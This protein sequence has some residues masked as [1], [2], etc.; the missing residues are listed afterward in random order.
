MQTNLFQSSQHALNLNDISAKIRAVHTLYACWQAG[1]CVLEHDAE[2]EPIGPPGRPES[3]ELVLPKLLLTRKFSTLEGRAVMIHAIAH[4][5][6]NAINLALD[7]VYRF[8]HCPDAYYGDW[9][10][11]AFEESQHFMLLSN[12]L[13]ELGY[14]YGDFPAHNGLW[15]MVEKTAYDVLVRMALVPRVMEA[16]GLDVTPGIQ[17]KFASVGDTRMVEILEVIFR[18]EIGHVQIGNRWYHY[19][20]KQRQVDSLATFKQLAEKHLQTQIRLPFFKEARL[21]AGFSEEELGMLGEMV[22]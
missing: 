6:F 2:V 13:N 15:E 16:R 5:E 18:E 17:K 14:S 22:G 1:D 7:A 11:V 19:F 3:P 9:L 10:R 4:I 8:R 12:Y 21:K 20:C